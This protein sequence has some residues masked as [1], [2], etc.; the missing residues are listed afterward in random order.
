[1]S[2]LKVKIPSIRL[3]GD[4]QRTGSIPRHT[5]NKQKSWTFWPIRVSTTVALLSYQVHTHTHTKSH[6]CWLIYVYPWAYL[7]V[8]ICSSPNLRCAVSYRSL[9]SSQS[10]WHAPD[11]YDRPDPCKRTTHL[12]YLKHIPTYCRQSIKFPFRCTL[13][14]SFW[15]ITTVRSGVTKQNTTSGFFST[16]VMTYA[17]VIIS[18]IKKGRKS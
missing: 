8:W 11:S 18:V 6:R 17:T 13:S 2:D 3:S 14:K 10:C 4:I 15:N 5:S 7:C 12:L 1:M 9:K 16:M